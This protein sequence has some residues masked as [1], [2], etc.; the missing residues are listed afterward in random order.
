[1]IKI[2]GS[3]LSSFCYYRCTNKSWIMICGLQIIFFKN[4]IKF[5]RI[6]FKQ[7]A[8]RIFKWSDV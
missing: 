7:W 1:M 8:W 6:Q 4:K 3:M 5:N 2:I